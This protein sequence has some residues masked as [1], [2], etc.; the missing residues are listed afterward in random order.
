[1]DTALWVVK[2]GGSLQRA[3]ELPQWL[4]LIERVATGNV[5]VVPGGGAFADAVR[6]AQQTWHFDDTHAHRMA[7]LA[8]Q[9]MAWLLRGLAPTYAIVE[10]CAKIRE[11]LKRGRAVL[12]APD[13]DELDAAGIPASWEITSDSLAAW[14]AGVLSAHCLVLIKSASCGAASGP[15]RLAARGIV[16]AALPRYCAE[17]NAALA[18]FHRAELQAFERFFTSCHD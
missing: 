11:A 16:D 5:V 1:M 9:Q 15:Q 7:I 8:M 13:A 18:V 17:S 2:L 6:D 4:R 14:L 12:W 3:A 10:S